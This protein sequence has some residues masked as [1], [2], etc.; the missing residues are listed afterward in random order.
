MTGMFTPFKYMNEFSRLTVRVILLSLGLFQII[1]FKSC[2]QGSATVSKI[3]KTDCSSLK[4]L[5][6]VVCLAEA[7]KASLS[8]EQAEQ[9]Q[10]KYAKDQAVRWSNF[11]QFVAKRVGLSLGSL[12]E[13]QLT[14][15]KKLMASVLSNDVEGEG[16][17]E[18][19]SGRA[20]DDYLGKV[21]G[22]KNVFS[23]GQFYITFLGK[24]SII[25]LWEL[26]YGGHHFA[27][28]NTYNHGKL[29]GATPSF[30]GLEPFTFTDNGRVFE[31]MKN[32]RDAFATMLLNLAPSEQKKARLPS[33]F[34][35]VLLGPLVDG[36][37]PITK[38]GVR[39][40][41]LSESKK[42]L[43]L[44]A[45]GFYVNDLESASAETILR[46]Y[47]KELIETYIAF[48]GSGTMDSAGDYVRIDGPNIWIEYS[49]QAS[50][51]F[52]GTVHPHSV[53]RDKTGDYGGN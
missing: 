33:T 18:L 44:N 24:P 11:P 48:S 45:I 29:T 16:F 3:V 27:F 40:G 23:S 47:K 53:W 50:R 39:V 43:V 9:L 46:K 28:A 14:A 21:T 42:E 4:G 41:D 6:Q 20:A 2:A 19:E 52:P 26:Q 1:S 49:S 15:A 36:K 35:D 13:T 34:K 17:D 10:R 8:T 38:Q 30:R 5:E 32:E 22:K 51:D 31:S 25:D 37:F 7:F 12:D